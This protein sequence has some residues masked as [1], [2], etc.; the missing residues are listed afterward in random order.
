MQFENDTLKAKARSLFT[1]KAQAGIQDAYKQALSAKGDAVT[2]KTIFVQNCS[3][4]HQVRGEMGEAIGPD[5]GTVHNWSAEAV[6]ENTLSPNLSI[7]SG[8]DTW[9]VELLNNETVTGVIASETPGAITIR[10]AGGFERT[11]GRHDIK[12]LKA[13]NMSLMPEG[14]EAQISPEQM[15]DL[16]AFLKGM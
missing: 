9:S 7:S 15:V 13:L 5:L 3:L 11:I 1:S 6:M 16:V 4:C 12:S 8:F 2:G 10:N 14:M